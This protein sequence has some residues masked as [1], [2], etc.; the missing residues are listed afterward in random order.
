[1]VIFKKQVPEAANF[2]SR[3]QRPEIGC[4]MSLIYQ[5]VIA[6]LRSMTRSLSQQSRTEDLVLKGYPRNSFRVCACEDLAGEFRILIL[7]VWENFPRSC[8]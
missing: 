6:G 7:A 3:T 4:H 5:P 8:R 1:M 2:A